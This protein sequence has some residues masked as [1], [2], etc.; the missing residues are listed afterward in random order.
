[1]SIDE[2]VSFERSI[3]LV[4]AIDPS[5]LPD[6]FMISEYPVSKSQAITSPSLSR[7]G[8]FSSLLTELP[9]RFEIMIDCLTPPASCHLA[10]RI[11]RSFSVEV[12]IFDVPLINL[13]L[14]SSSAVG[15][16]DQ[17]FLLK[18]RYLFRREL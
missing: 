10:Y 7:A 2:Y 17:T 15:R 11:M 16:Y 1:V 3:V 12:G 14:E 6:G 18:I 4:E 13:V 5:S 9:R 8:S